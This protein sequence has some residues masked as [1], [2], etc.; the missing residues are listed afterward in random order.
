MGKKFGMDPQTIYNAYQHLQNNHGM[1]YD[2]E[3]FDHLVQDLLQDFG[4]EERGQQFINY[5][6]TFS[7]GQSKEQ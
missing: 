4:S 3:K 5:Y 6:N 1:I 2:D 7:F